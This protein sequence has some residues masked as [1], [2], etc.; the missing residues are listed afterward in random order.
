M[1]SDGHLSRGIAGPVQAW[2][3]D[4]NDGQKLQAG[5]TL[6]VSK[7]LPSPSLSLFCP[8]LRARQSQ[9]LSAQDVRA[10]RVETWTTGLGGHGGHAGKGQ[11]AKEVLGGAG[12]P[13][14]GGLGRRL[15]GVDPW[16]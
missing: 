13:R 2:P 14:L 10:R 9:P 7:P 6:Q 3:V 15:L 1:P 12:P 16:E 5:E 4:W 8:I 11:R